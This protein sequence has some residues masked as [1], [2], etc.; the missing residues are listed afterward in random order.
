[1]AGH[2]LVNLMLPPASLLLQQDI[3]S[4]DTVGQSPVREG[5]H[6]GRETGL[7]KTGKSAWYRV[8]YDGFGE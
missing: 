4:P 2:F 3:V 6:M 1:M 5:T 7:Y 8:K